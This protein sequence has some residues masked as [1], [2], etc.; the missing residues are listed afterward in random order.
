MRNQK[1]KQ[2][3]S[4][5]MK[6]FDDTTLKKLLCQFYDD[7]AP[8]L[9]DLRV[10]S[11]PIP[12]VVLGDKIQAKKYRRNLGFQLLVKLTEISYDKLLF[13]VVDMEEDLIQRTPDQSD[14]DP[15]K[16][17]FVPETCAIINSDHSDI[18]PEGNE[19]DEH[20]VTFI[21]ETQVPVKPVPKPQ[22][23]IK[24]V[25]PPKVPL[26]KH[27]FDEVLGDCHEI[28]G[29]EQDESPSIFRPQKKTKLPKKMSPPKQEVKPEVKPEVKEEVMKDSVEI[30]NF[31][32]TQK[33]KKVEKSPEGSPSILKSSRRKRLEAVEEQLF[34]NEEHTVPQQTKE[35]RLE[36][37]AEQVDFH[38]VDD[39]DDF[40]EEKSSS[41]SLNKKPMKS[42]SSRNKNIKAPK[43]KFGMEVEEAT[44]SQLARV[45]SLKQ[46]S[47][48]GFFK[49]PPSR[50]KSKMKSKEDEDIALAIERSKE[51]QQRRNIFD[52]CYDPDEENDI[53][54]I[55]SKKREDREKLTG[56]SCRDCER[57]YAQANLNTEQLQDVIQKCSRHRAAAEDVPDPGENS[58]QALWNLDFDGPDNKTQVGSPLKGR[59]RR[60]NNY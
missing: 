27:T 39:D 19:E 22:K 35:E 3:I 18:E 30:F 45:Q 24:K 17:D 5:K 6:N 56:F 32:E 40:K 7:L 57:Y 33:P 55:N 28:F 2:V 42:S 51:D 14:L 20:E 43:N 16:P 48:S 36:M 52:T 41:R 4:E 38:I 58:P 12:S 59:K 21:P 23:K 1:R 9:S 26:K 10:R 49:N 34:F 60:R 50:R 25:S 44:A 37:L 46:G 54:F 29:I 47:I 13:K 31:G 11:W 53:N 8:D 15:T